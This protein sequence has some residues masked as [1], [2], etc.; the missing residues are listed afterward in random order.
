M[1]YAILIYSDDCDLDSMTGETKNAVLAT[2]HD[3]QA[4]LAEKGKFATAKLMPVN[5]AVTV[6]HSPGAGPKP[7]VLDGPFA[8]TKERFLGFYV[9]EC[10]NLEE[11][12]EYA[13]MLSSPYATLEVRPVAW[14]GGIFGE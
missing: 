8:E 9:V 3:L 2:H 6:R 1:H 5:N 12:I 7:L 4:K 13:S 10:E 11:A 14:A